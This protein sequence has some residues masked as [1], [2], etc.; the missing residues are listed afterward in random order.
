MYK[1]Y[2]NKYLALWPIICSI[3]LVASPL[4]AQYYQFKNLTTTD[5]IPSNLIY[6]SYQDNYGFIWFVTSEGLYRYDGMRYEQFLHNPQDPTS[7]SGNH[8]RCIYQDIEGDMWIGT[9]INGLNRFDYNTGKFSRFK[10]D[11]L[12]NTSISNN[13]IL[14]ITED[15]HG[16]IWVGTED[17]LNAYDKSDGT[18]TRYIYNKNNPNSIG[19][20]S[21][22]SLYH[23]YK[24]RLWL[25]TWA[26]GLSLAVVNNT[27]TP[28]KDL[29]FV[30]IKA[31]EKEKNSIVGNN[32]W[33]ITQDN[34][35]NYWINCFGDGISLMKLDELEIRNSKFYNFK[36][37]IGDAS[38]ISNNYNYHIYADKENKLWISSVNGVSVSEPITFTPN[39]DYDDIDLK[40]ERVFAEERANS[41]VF[42]EVRHIMNDNTGTLWLSTFGGISK[43]NFYN[44]AFES[45]LTEKVVEY[46]NSVEAIWMEDSTE[47]W[48]GTSNQGLIKYNPFTDEK[49]EYEKTKA[50]FIK[51]I[52]PYDDN[53]FWLGHLNGFSIFDK[54]TGNKVFYELKH[55]EGI[56]IE[57]QQVH[58]IIRDKNEQIWLAT[59][60]GLVK[61][62][63]NPIR[64]EYYR[65]NPQNPNSL[66][67][68]NVFDIVEDEKGNFW[69]A[70]FGGL[71]YLSFDNDKPYFT[72]YLANTESSNALGSNRLIRLFL[73]KDKLWIGTE[74]GLY[75]YHLKNKTFTN[76]QTSE[77][78]NLTFIYSIMKDNMGR[79]WCGARN[80]IYCYN[81]ATKEIIKYSSEDGLKGSV[82]SPLGF[83]KD[84]NGRLYYGT[85]NG[86]NTFYGEK[87][88]ANSHP[89][90][91][92]ITK[93]KVN[94]KEKN[95]GAY[96]GK[97]DRIV[98]TPKERM[99]SIE[100]A[101]LD[102]NNSFQN[103]YA[104][105]L[106]GVDKDW[107][108][109]GNRQ[110]VNY[111]NLPEGVYTFRVKAVN[112][113][114]VWNE[115]GA[116]L[117]IV[118]RP[119]LI[120]RT[121]FRLIVILGL[122]GLAYV[123]Y[124]Y[125]IGEVTKQKNKLQSVVDQLTQE[126]QRGDKLVTQLEKRNNELQT[127]NK[128]LEQFA[129]IASHD[130][131]E[132]LRMMGNFSQVLEEEYSDKLG[133]EGKTYINY[134]VDNAKRM[135]RQL[136]E[137]L[138]Y[139][140]V[141]S[142]AAVLSSVEVVDLFTTV[143]ESMQEY[144]KSNNVEIFFHTVPSEIMANPKDL[145]EVVQSLI[146]NAIKFNDSKK[147][148]ININ[149]E[150]QGAYWCF[151]IVDNGIGIAPENYEKVFEVFKRLHRK[152][153]YSGT[154]IG[155]ALAKRIIL[156]YGG[157]IWV[158]ST[159]GKGSTFYF[160]LPKMSENQ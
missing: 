85:D 131:Q 82:F 139:S 66:S 16:I 143:I 14:A 30:T 7:I 22:L 64:F 155:L 34:N 145:G 118:A 132:P 15:K 158:E 58:K 71:N 57:G 97:L 142:K 59:E 13:Q 76:H 25:G 6:K 63:E 136:D 78:K 124:Y 152:E 9:Q 117:R 106:E 61:V 70:T 37:K 151:S 72:R 81:I 1:Q 87:L 8:I 134:I 89:P 111:S 120:E 90:L 27:A 149:I 45:R 80:A 119:P 99:F 115:E 135:S 31:K 103:Q 19:G 49:Q 3:I 38:T 54:R 156:K 52:F 86:Y 147:P 113:R 43:Y 60:G 108:Y 107:V 114:G 35:L 79:Y 105:Q 96:I 94:N 68:N 88:T 159:L 104:Y 138:K 5:G 93:F 24:D 150:E 130:L 157:K 84:N 21:V 77:G 11:T 28:H 48:I 100:Y 128:A 137:L 2:S 44:P 56:E 98:L 95:F 110:S 20:A 92:L 141:G 23:D 46:H 67:H 10:N 62:L 126:K 133:K 140:L 160:T 29:S 112:S 148:S 144:I 53:T 74:D 42:N 153:E 50:Q 129:Y 55:P 102:F 75:T 40:F 12:D 125:R 18:F 33:H 36:Q 91:V 32:V 51:N 39:D 47:Q 69:I 41:L 65:N 122:L 127:S 26:G 121:Y 109:A 116:S 4:Y 73:E 83:F 101:A 123:I 146:H 17:G 154:G